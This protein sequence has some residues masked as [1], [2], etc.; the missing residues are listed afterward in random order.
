MSY[1]FTYQT[2]LGNAKTIKNKAEKEHEKIG[3]G[4]S[5]YIAKAI[6]NPKKDI[7]KIT[8]KG[9]SKSSGDDFSRQIDKK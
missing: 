7:K 1:V 8:V 3:A 6:L 9:A 2:I 4:W 5:Y